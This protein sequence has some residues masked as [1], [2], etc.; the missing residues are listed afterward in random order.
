MPVA[1]AM[2]VMQA[3]RICRGSALHARLTVKTPGGH[4][5]RVRW[6]CCRPVGKGSGV[7]THQERSH[8]GFPEPWVLEVAGESAWQDFTSS[9][10]TFCKGE[11][12]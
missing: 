8:G 3:V 11:R 5:G 4:D 2:T 12:G 1:T 9:G 7:V 10:P 6:W